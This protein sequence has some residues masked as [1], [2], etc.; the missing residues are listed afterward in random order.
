MAKFLAG[1]VTLVVFFVSL[2]AAGM[3]QQE[4]LATVSN[5][6]TEPLQ[7]EPQLT[8]E[9]EL[10]AE[11]EAL[12]V[13]Q[14]ECWNRGDL[15]GFMATYWKS[16]DLTFSGSGSTTRGWQQTYDRYVAR[17]HPPEKMGQLHFD[18]LET[19]LL[20]DSAALVLGN[21]H[22]LMTDG[23][24]RDGN[25]SLVMSKMD[26]GWKIIHDHSSTLEPQDAG[27]AGEEKPAVEDDSTNSETEKVETAGEDGE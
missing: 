6:E 9:T 20:G 14:D 10:V 3:H 13:A 12:L 2:F 18:G 5:Q 16:E 27:E 11:L 24:T 26:D 23:E 17:Y 15:E 7:S 22:L 19:T 1:R 4:M 8:T 25:F 21:W